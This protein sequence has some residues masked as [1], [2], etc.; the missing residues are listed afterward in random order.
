MKSLRLE[1]HL[2]NK[3]LL[4]VNLIIPM[5]PSNVC[6]VVID[7]FPKDDLKSYLTKN[8]KT[9]PAFE[10]IIQLALDLA[11]GSKP[12]DFESCYVYSNG[13]CLWEIYCCVDLSFSEV[14]SAVL[15]SVIGLPAASLK[16]VFSSP[17]FEGLERQVC[18][19]MM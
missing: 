14:T 18:T 11:R 1:Q 15:Q 2:R 10:A 12:D 7:D 9:R 13:I 8:Q 19:R 17:G 3:L 16:V 5:W 6:C 4:G